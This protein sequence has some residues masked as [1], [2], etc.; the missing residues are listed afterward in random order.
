MK[1]T[2]NLEFFINRVR[3]FEQAHLTQNADSASANIAIAMNSLYTHQENFRKVGEKL[4]GLGVPAMEAKEVPGLGQFWTEAAVEKIIGG[5]GFDSE[6]RKELMLG[7]VEMMKVVTAFT[8]AL[9]QLAVID[10]TLKKDIINDYGKLDLVTADGYKFTDC[11]SGKYH[12]LEDPGID[13]YLKRNAQKQVRLMATPDNETWAKYSQT[14]DNGI[15]VVP[16]ST[17]M[18]KIEANPGG[19]MTNSQVGTIALTKGDSYNA[20]QRGTVLMEHGQC[21]DGSS[22]AKAWIKGTRG[23]LFRDKNTVDRIDYALHRDADPL[24]TKAV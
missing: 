6:V 22:A 2:H 14:A 15:A 17:V 5:L 4:A 3:E 12:D 19:W 10:P 9:M 21:I 1:S 18:T 23:E 24:F 20:V 13:I 16:L 8:D 7:L 11:I